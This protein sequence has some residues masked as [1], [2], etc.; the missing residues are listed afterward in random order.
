MSWARELAG[1]ET[2]WSPAAMS[3]RADAPYG[4]Q[5]TSRRAARRRLAAVSPL[6]QISFW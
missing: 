4:L 6:V 2:S 1:S 3:L 5:S